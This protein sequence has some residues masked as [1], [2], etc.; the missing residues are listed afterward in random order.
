MDNEIDF[1]GFYRETLVDLCKV[2]FCDSSI[3]QKIA[4]DGSNNQKVRLQVLYMQA[5]TF[6]TSMD[7]KETE[8]TLQSTE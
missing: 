8:V 3:H 6:F 2:M 7:S 1:Q 5:T 4:W